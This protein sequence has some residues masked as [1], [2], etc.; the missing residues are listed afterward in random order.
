[1]NPCEAPFLFTK[2]QDLDI[3]LDWRAMLDQW[4]ILI[5]T[6]HDDSPIAQACV[7][8]SWRA[9]ENLG[10]VDAHQYWNPTCCNA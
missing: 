5:A 4:N 3:D 1:L 10:L 6:P 7:V 9:I 2:L 8:S